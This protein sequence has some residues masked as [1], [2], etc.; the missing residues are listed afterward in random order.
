ML[1]TQGVRETITS[2][3]KKT[4]QES[5]QCERAMQWVALSAKLIVSMV[6]VDVVLVVYIYIS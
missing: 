1:R 3:C 2:Q 6:P 5:T 4:G